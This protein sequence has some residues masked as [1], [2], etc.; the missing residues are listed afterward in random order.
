LILKKLNAYFTYHI[1]KKITHSSLERWITNLY[2]QAKGFKKLENFIRKE[3]EIEYWK[4]H[5]TPEDIE[6]YECQLE[7][8]Q[9]LLTSYNRVERIIGMVLRFFASRIKSTS[10]KL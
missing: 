4:S 5:T 3:E 7:L 6:Y 9:N 8:Q 10:C 1:D 2:F